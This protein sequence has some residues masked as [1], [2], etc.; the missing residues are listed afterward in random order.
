MIEQ[1]AA[2]SRQRA[3]GGK[4]RKAANVFPYP[5]PDT[6]RL[7][8]YCL[9]PAAC[10]LLFAACAT[11]ARRDGRVVVTFWH[12]MESGINNKILQAKIDEFNHRHG[13][14]FIDAQVYGAAD[15]LGPKLD[16][17]VAG[18]TPPDLLWWAPAFFPK[19][20]EAGA[21]KSVDEFIAGDAGFKRDDVYD[22]LWEMGSFDGH[23]YA[24]PFSANNLGLYYNK[25]MFAE[26]GINEPPATWEGFREAA[27]ML[28]HG[29]RVRGFQIPIGSSEWT[30]WTWQCFLWQAGGE[31]LTPDKTAAAFNSPAGVAALDFWKSLLVENAA[32]FSETDAGY[33]TDDFLA[34]RVAMTINGPW[35]YPLLKEQTAIE[36]GA[37]ALPRQ[38]R[39]ATNIGGESLFLFK[40]TPEKEQAAW[41][42]MKFVMSSDFQ[43]DWAI[44][45]GYL[46]VS[47]SAANSARYEE[48]LQANPFMK[49]YNEQMPDGRTRPS[50]PQYPALSATLGKYLEAALYNKY[51]SQEALDRAAQEVNVLLKK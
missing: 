23:V 45:T 18:K 34:S 31:I 33:K 41:E 4:R 28:S 11:T 20:A 32:V 26:A 50:I 16:A 24:T 13:G 40:S 29:E 22:F 44:N 2:G 19:Y 36:A 1:Q 38:D 37:F 51:S 5:M 48:F 27:L 7:L 47:K 14:I 35:N 12:G 6:Y 9:L 46:P 39:A 43:I 17:A 25:R 10:C 21:L 15:Q 30:V 3:V 42:F 49:V 8:L